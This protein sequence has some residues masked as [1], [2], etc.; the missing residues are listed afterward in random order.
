MKKNLIVLLLTI[1]SAFS[2]ISFSQKPIMGG[3]D[4][5]EGLYP[6]MAGLAYSEET[7]IYWAH[8]CGASLIDE[9]WVLTAAH[10]LMNEYGTGPAFS[11]EIDV[12]FNV[13][14]LKN[15][16]LDMLR[17]E[18]DSFYIHPAYDDYSLDSDIGLIR[19]KEP[20]AFNTIFI[21]EQNDVA[22]LEPGYSSRTIGW[23]LLDTMDTY[24]SI[25]QEVDIEIIQF[26]I[27]NSVSSYDGELT[28]NM[29]CVG[30]MV[31]GK[32]A[33]GGDS[34]GPLFIDVDGQWFQNG[35]VSW[36]YDCGAANYP[37]IYT[38]VSK[39]ANWIESIIG[40]D[41]T[42]PVPPSFDGWEIAPNIVKQYGQAKTKAIINAKGIKLNSQKI[43]KN[44]AVYDQFGRC[45]LNEAGLNSNKLLINVSLPSSGIYLLRLIYDDGSM[46][47]IKSL[48]IL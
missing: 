1:L 14:D 11:N 26:D 13:Y 17:V 5:T 27:C 21:P 3:R 8:F 7:D 15:P 41:I 31:G 30:F 43:I 9:Y 12:F 10:C 32:D 4:A 29:V 48:A 35:L 36:G 38:K 37:G 34:G 42:Q 20:V 47:T 19:L 24:A 33:C 40:K 46:E 25:L 23:G 44:A 2:Q 6:W 39:Y 18:S 22:L 28:S 16:G 45:L